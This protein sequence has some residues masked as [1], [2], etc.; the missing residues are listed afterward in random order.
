MMNNN[1]NNRPT[2][3]VTNDDGINAKGIKAL[4]EVVRPLGNVVVVGPSEA[5]SGMSHAITVKDPLFINKIKEEDGLVVYSLNGTPADCVKL[6]FNKV[7]NVKP[8]LVVSGINHG[9]NSSVSVHYSGT[10]GAARE[11]ALYGVPSIA[12]SLLDYMPDADF[13][14]SLHFCR[15]IVSYFLE[16]GMDNGVYMNVNIPKGENLE[17]IKICRQANGIWAEEFDE[18]TTPRG[19]KYY[20]L[21]GQ[22]KN[23]EVE[24]E[25]TDEWAL[26]NGY[27][28]VVPCSVDLTAY[29]TLKKL[30]NSK[31][32]TQNVDVEK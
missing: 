6:G 14:S 10:V 12:F 16:N 5:M 22:F 25:D 21:T 9:T 7:L 20:W 24:S 2:I 19:S 30:Q 23:N 31:I 27:V 4:V 17:G 1:I 8:D 32:N 18:R 3:L 29:N 13:K 26:N 15:E 11:G 28:S